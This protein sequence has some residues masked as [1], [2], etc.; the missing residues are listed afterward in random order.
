MEKINM[1]A[2]FLIYTN[3]KRARFT[4]LRPQVLPLCQGI[5]GQV[6]LK[7]LVVSDG[8]D[9]ILIGSIGQAMRS[10]P[11]PPELWRNIRPLIFFS[12]LLAH[13]PFSPFGHTIFHFTEIKTF[14]YLRI[15]LPTLC[16]AFPSI[17]IT[18]WIRTTETPLL[19]SHHIWKSLSSS[20]IYWA[21]SGS[22][23]IFLDHNPA[24][25]FWSYKRQA[26]PKQNSDLQG[27]R[28]KLRQTSI[29]IFLAEAC[30]LPSIMKVSTACLCLFLTD[31]ILIKQM[32]A[33]PGEI[34]LSSSK[35][36]QVL[37]IPTWTILNLLHRKRQ[38]KEH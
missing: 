9:S 25:I 36:R 33:Q 8:R 19:P 34:Y 17:S 6:F 37:N 22:Y 30:V 21:C 24:L 16:S 28:D 4:S 27:G 18:H 11:R 1:C 38:G 35:L 14:H 12:L 15:S 31:A 3:T 20:D 13:L 32:L 29:S 2:Q 10:H 23:L 7:S 5:L 26:E